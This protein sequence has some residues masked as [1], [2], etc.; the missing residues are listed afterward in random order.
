VQQL[1]WHLL[2][3]TRGGFN[4]LRILRALLGEPLNASQLANQLGLDYRTVRHHIEI[5][6][7]NGILA[8]PSGDAYG[9]RLV[10]SGLMRANLETLE[11]IEERIHLLEGRSAPKRA[12]G[13]A[14]AGGE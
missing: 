7:E 6:L 11:F 3:S 1:L 13:P 5:L 9:S 14:S 12:P 4:R 2:A 8:R 10:V